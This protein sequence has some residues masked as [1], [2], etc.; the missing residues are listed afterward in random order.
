MQPRTHGKRDNPSSESGSNANGIRFVVPADLVDVVVPPTMSDA[1]SNA[2]NVSDV[3]YLE[4]LH[5]GFAAGA[6]FGPY[7]DKV[8]FHVIASS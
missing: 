3:R 2:R 4:A 8:R 7:E 6:V 5:F 1:V